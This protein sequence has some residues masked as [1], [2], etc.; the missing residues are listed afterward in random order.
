[1]LATA[2]GEGRA[3]RGTMSWPRIQPPGVSSRLLASQRRGARPCGEGP[4][5]RSPCVVAWG[6][7][8]SPTGSGPACLQRGL[9]PDSGWIPL[10]MRR[11]SNSASE[12]SGSMLH[13]EGEGPRGRSR[14]EM[15]GK[16]V[17]GLRLLLWPFPAET[18]GSAAVQMPGLP[19]RRQLNGSH[20]RSRSVV[21]PRLGPGFRPARR[22]AGL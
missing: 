22:A 8:R 5:G 19:S 4:G 9:S 2:A 20:K 21:S 17:P 10:G 18:E 11:V 14:R 12:V 15:T 13:T 3:V 16:G 7:R 1:M 6:P